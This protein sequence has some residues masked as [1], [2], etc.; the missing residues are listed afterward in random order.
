HASNAPASSVRIED[1]TPPR[2]S[3]SATATASPA[4][5]A[6]VEGAP[7][8]AQANAQVTVTVQPSS[9]SPAMQMD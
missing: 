5:V 6:S 7:T 9:G 3:S 8:I 2:E 4:V 1:V